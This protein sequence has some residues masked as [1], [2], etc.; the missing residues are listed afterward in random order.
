MREALEEAIEV[1]G[2]EG[3][4]EEVVIMALHW[5]ATTL[6]LERGILPSSLVST[7]QAVDVAVRGGASS[8]Q[9]GRES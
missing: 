9:A 7:I 2:E 5:Q 1:A 6:C 3:V 4:E 8:C